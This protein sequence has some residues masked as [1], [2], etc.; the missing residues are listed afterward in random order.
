MSIEIKDLSY[1][2][3]PNSPFENAALKHINLHVEQGD[4]M[5]IIGHTGSGKSTLVSHLNALTKIQSGTITIDDI[6]LMSKQDR[7]LL[8]KQSHTKSKKPDLKKLRAKVG[9]VFQY[10]EYQLFDETV[11]RDVGFG[12][13]N[14]GIDGEERAIR[15]RQA[16]EMVGL[17]FDA[18]K[19]RSPF[20]L[21]GGQKRRVAIAGVLAMRP[22][23]L[24]LDEPTAGLDPRGKKEILSL[25]QKIKN[26][27]C[28]TIIMISHNMDEVA[29]VC[30]KI[31]VM[32]DGELKCILPPDELFG[33][34]ELLKE[35]HIQMPMVTQIACRLN[36]SGLNIPRNLVTQADLVE[37]IIQAKKS[38]GKQI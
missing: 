27:M 29:A 6:V 31:A 8:D 26:N 13:K 19:D 10:P 24:V 37:A 1:V 14:L 34:E 17:D 2:Y 30:S 12:P 20:D 25:V 38:G 23:V 16:I 18:L 33:Q 7:K 3:S 9:M 11:E 21:S 22:E 15:V 36:A 35:L 5:G 32:A 4:F 28:H